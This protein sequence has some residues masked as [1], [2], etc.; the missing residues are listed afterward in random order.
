[1]R[2]APGSEL[3]DLLHKL[4]NTLGELND[5]FG[6]RDLIV[7]ENREPSLKSALAREVEL[8]LDVRLAKF[9]K[10]RKSARRSTG[11]NPLWPS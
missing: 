5:L 8:R 6:L 3:L 4:Q 11:E 2:D 9:R 10:M 1:M 7:S